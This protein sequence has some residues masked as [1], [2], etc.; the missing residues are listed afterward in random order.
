MAVIDFYFDVDTRKRVTSIAD[1][2]IL[3]MPQFGQGNTYT[4]RIRALQPTGAPVGS[5]PYTAIQNSGKTIQLAISKTD[6][7]TILTNQFTWGL[8]ADPA[9]PYFYADIPFNTS[10]IN[11]ALPN[12]ATTL[13]AILEINLVDGTPKRLFKGDIVIDGSIIAN[14]TVTVP[15]G[16]TP[17]TMEAVL[18]LLANLVTDSLTIRSG[19]RS[20]QERLWI[21]NDG[22]P[23][24]DIS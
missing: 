19:D 11:A 12:G 1:G 13:P 22:S 10:P 2:S 14:Q 15:A 6:G 7:S 17:A 5:N 24:D 4:F 20:H 23:H 21:D 18:A 8:N 9:D 3:P 16:F